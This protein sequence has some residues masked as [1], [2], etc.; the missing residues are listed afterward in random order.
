MPSATRRAALPPIKTAPR[1][2]RTAAKAAE[3]ARTRRGNVSAVCC[4]GRDHA[5]K[6]EKS[7]RASVCLRVEASP[8][9]RPQV[10]RRIRAHAPRTRLALARYFARNSLPGP[11]ASMAEASLSVSVPAWR[12]RTDAEIG[13]GISKLKVANL[14]RRNTDS[15]VAACRLDRLTDPNYRCCS[16]W[17]FVRAHAPSASGEAPVRMRNLTHYACK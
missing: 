7:D 15:C 11:S 14:R 9:P 12:L 6:T 8:Q 5:M 4:D 13:G 10:K 17:G 16:Y 3:A 2:S 1:A